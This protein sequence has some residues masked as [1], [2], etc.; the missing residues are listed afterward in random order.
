MATF[1][2]FLL[3]SDGD[4]D[5]SGNQINM[6]ED[7]TVIAQQVE[8]NLKLSKKDWFLNFDEGITFFDN[9]NGLLGA[10]TV[11]TFIEAELQTAVLST[12]GVSSLNDFEYDLTTDSLDVNIIALTIF[13]EEDIQATLEL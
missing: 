9:D 2:D 4:L 10:K 7:I 6:A 13:G 3:T 12:N 8:T 5:I 11:T 1:A